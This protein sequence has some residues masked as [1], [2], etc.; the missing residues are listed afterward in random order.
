V[1]VDPNLRPLARQER[2]LRAVSVLGISN[3]SQDGLPVNVMSVGEMDGVV[4][5]A[6]RMIDR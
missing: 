6:G 1:V 5:I 3:S 4:Y 2:C